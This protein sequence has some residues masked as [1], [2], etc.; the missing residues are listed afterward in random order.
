MNKLN[1]VNTSL[2]Y[3]KLLNQ[4]WQP[5]RKH[6]Y[7]LNVNGRPIHDNR[8]KRNLFNEY[9]TSIQILKVTITKF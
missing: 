4:K 5:S 9:F 6:S 8:I 7:P 2:I 3:W 1:V